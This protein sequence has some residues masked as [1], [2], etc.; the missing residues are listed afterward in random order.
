M[1]SRV[2]YVSVYKH[3]Y[4]P[5]QFVMIVL[6]LVDFLHDITNPKMTIYTKS[7]PHS[8][9]LSFADDTTSITLCIRD[10]HSCDALR[11]K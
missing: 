7:G 10:L 2:C 4:N 1:R 5:K 9:I 11:E 3:R 6:I 8:F